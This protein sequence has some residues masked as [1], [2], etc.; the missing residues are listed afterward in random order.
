MLLHHKK[1]SFCYISILKRV[2][3]PFFSASLWQ[4]P[5][6]RPIRHKDW[7][8]P[9]GKQH[10]KLWAFFP[11]AT[12]QRTLNRTFH[13]PHHRGNPLNDDRERKIPSHCLVIPFRCQAGVS[14]VRESNMDSSRW[15]SLKVIGSRMR[16]YTWGSTCSHSKLSH[17][18]SILISQHLN[19]WLL[20]RVITDSVH[21]RFSERIWKSWEARL[22]QLKAGTE[23]HD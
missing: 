8:G 16:G 18:W 13:S 22:P 5:L 21:M 9:L 17:L 1:W 11:P 3:I 4:I 20:W 15:M 6:G 10:V 12:L 19:L 23:A 7:N 2:L 14:L